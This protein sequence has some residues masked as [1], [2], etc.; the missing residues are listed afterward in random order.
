MYFHYRHVGNTWACY[1]TLRLHM[2]TDN[3][4][5]RLRYVTL[6]PKTPTQQKKIRYVTQRRHMPTSIFKKI[7]TLRNDVICTRTISKK[8]L[9][10]L[11]NDVK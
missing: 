5:I 10:S 1:V 11:R 3:E 2:P 7:V 4:K 6:A 9:V 8:K